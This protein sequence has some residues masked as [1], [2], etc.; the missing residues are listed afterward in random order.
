LIIILNKMKSNVLSSFE[1]M[2]YFTIEGFREVT[3]EDSSDQCVRNLLH[4][5]VKA[6]HLL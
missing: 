4:R 3:G 1:N 6:G 5:W 2:P